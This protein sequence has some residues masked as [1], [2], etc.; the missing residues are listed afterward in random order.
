ME[1]V[2]VGSSCINVVLKK[3]TGSR[4][5]TCA[6]GT[7]PSVLRNEIIGLNPHAVSLHGTA[8]KF[9]RFIREARANNLFYLLISLSEF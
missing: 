9:S 7:R 3:K 1:P 8:G 5:P 4:P 6:D 2:G